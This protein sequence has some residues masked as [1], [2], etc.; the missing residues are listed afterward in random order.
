MLSKS[1]E[2]P[3]DASSPDHFGIEYS[4]SNEGLCKECNDTIFY[5]EIRVKT[6]IYDSEIASKFGKEIQWH[7]LHCFVFS[8]EQH[9][10]RLSGEMLPGF[11]DLQE[12]HQQIVK[13]AI[14]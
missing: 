13:D 14:L 8:R 2:E 10:F 5:N 6:T 3:S 12:I 9:G 4:T 1:V 7:H 11:N